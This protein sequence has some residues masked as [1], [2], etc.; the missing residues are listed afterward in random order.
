MP[1]HTS[2]RRRRWKRWLLAVIPVAVIV[3]L[4]AAWGIDLH[5]HDGR[6]SRNVS[7]A[8][9]DVGGDSRDE[10]TA[11][12]HRD[13]AAAQT[14][15]VH[16]VT[17]TATFDTTAAA[18]G[19]SLDEPATV[20]A[21]LHVGHEGSP[22]LRPIRWVSS[23]FSTRKV[24][25]HY[26]VDRATAAS[27]VRTIEGDAHVDPVEPSLAA[28]PDGTI[29]VVAGTPGTG[30]DSDELTAALLAAAPN[31]SPSDPL[32]V[33]V[34]RGAIAPHFAD[35]DAQRVADQANGL[36]HR[37]LTITIGSMTQPI[38]APT[39]AS[40]LRA[41]PTADGLALGIDEAAVIGALGMQF[42][43]AGQPAVDATFT[44]EDGKP[45][46]HPSQDGTGCCEPGTGAKVFDAL[47]ANNATLT[48]AVTVQHPQLTT[49]AAKQLGIVE[50]VGQPDMFGPTTHHA[51]CQSRVTNIHL[52][53]DIV[54]GHVI[55]PGETFSVNDFVGKRTAARGFVDAP[56]IYDATEAHDIGGGVSQFATTMFNA[57]FFAGMDLVEYQSHSIY[58]SRYPRGREATISWPSPD[59]KVKNSTPYGMLIWPTYDDTTL[60]VH[61][62]ST[63]FVDVAA[64]PTSDKPSGVCTRVT[65][66][67]TRTYVDGHVANDSVS[68]L[69][70]P[71]DGV[72][73]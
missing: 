43:A 63:H 18:L 7:L 45:V 60:T 26:A 54:R 61:L 69:Y 39:I 41:V 13:A 37:S 25:A 16:V 9:H 42:G 57:S 20:A 14:A 48:L 49:D 3:V 47:Q 34:G 31:R 40:W 36:T 22:L 1:R 59:L 29:T 65:T 68:A 70:Q 11:E 50:E 6:V 51:C 19:L 67:R 15:P 35:A 21:V 17:P 5:G 33:H 10:L 27:D 24:K 72:R 56:V 58:L 62:Y 52:I 12:V 71:A 64:G 73:C 44:V 28:A 66:P 8:G 46:L 53:A 4:L 38:A 23:I 2:T 55:L 30:I 32:A